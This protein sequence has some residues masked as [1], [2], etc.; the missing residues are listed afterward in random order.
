[1]HKHLQEYESV[2]IFA[3]AIINNIEHVPLVRAINRTESF[4]RM[5]G[6]GVEENEFLR[7]AAWREY[8]D[9]TGLILSNIS[10]EGTLIKDD[11]NQDTS[12]PKNHK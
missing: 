4:W 11:T 1:M 9:E 8:K 6:G 5:P 10:T 3:I 2:L 12:S 7:Q